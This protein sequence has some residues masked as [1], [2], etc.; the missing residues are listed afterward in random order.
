MS[1]FTNES[2]L[3]GRVGGG[4]HCWELSINSGFWFS[5]HYS[6][7][8]MEVAAI[9]LTGNLLGGDTSHEFVDHTF[10]TRDK[11][12]LGCL[13]L[14]S[15][16]FIVGLIRVPTDHSRVAGNCK[17]NE[18]AGSGTFISLAAEWKRLGAPLAFCGSLLY[19]WTL[20]ELCKRWTV[21]SN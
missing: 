4:V 15:S 12:C 13:F 8:Q 1:Y 9:K 16:Y 21:A 18:L 5:H 2:K 3:A 19:G 17:A 11:G 20:D 7:F 10:E 14:P 6:V